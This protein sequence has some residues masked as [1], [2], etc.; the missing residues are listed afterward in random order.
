VDA[1][2]S[3]VVD[4]EG[5]V[6]VA[7]VALDWSLFVVLPASLVELCDAVVPVESVV[8]AGALAAL[9]ALVALEALEAPDA[10]RDVLAFVADCASPPLLPPP[11]PPHAVKIRLNKSAPM[12]RGWWYRIVMMNTHY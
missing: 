5:V 3:G 8:V 9:V 7:G 12:N 4:V 2:A 11:P 6:D 10:P 1:P